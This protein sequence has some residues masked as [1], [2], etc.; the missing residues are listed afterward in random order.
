MSLPYRHV[1]CCIDGSDAGAGALREARAVADAADGS[2]SV[3]HVIA[4]PHFV[5]SLA[6]G[7]G[8][9]PVH[10]DATEREAA[11]LWLAGAAEEVRGDP[12]LL[13]GHPASAASEWAA[14]AGVDLLV[15]ASHRGLVERSMLGSFAGYLV[16]HAPCAVL[17]TKPTS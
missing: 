8:G 9:A 5:V 17:L 6:A 1:A 16:H 14:E 4:P 13:E 3:V 7:L 12:V 15:A 11:R 10:D 2:L